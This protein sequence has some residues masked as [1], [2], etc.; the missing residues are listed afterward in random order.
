MVFARTPLASQR[1]PSPH[2]CIPLDR[3]WRHTVSNGPPSTTSSI[4]KSPD[5]L[6]TCK[7]GHMK[8]VPTR[9]APECAIRSQRRTRFLRVKR[10]TFVFHI[11]PGRRR[12]H[13][14]TVTH[15]HT[16]GC[17]ALIAL[18]GAFYPRLQFH[19]PMH[20]RV[21]HVRIFFFRSSSLSLF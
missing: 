5:V 14:L 18:M 15:I 20:D 10:T 13:T 17:V 7:R 11:G 12:M 19:V 16:R 1:K 6:E 9:N 2:D 3:G 21:H 8:Q 4:T